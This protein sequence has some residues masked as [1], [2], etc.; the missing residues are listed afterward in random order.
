[1]RSIALVVWVVVSGL[2]VTSDNVLAYLEGTGL[3]TCPESL[4]QSDRR[5]R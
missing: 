4:S 5:L 1:M 3:A 2:E